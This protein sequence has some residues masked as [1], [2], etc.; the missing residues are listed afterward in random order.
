MINVNEINRKINAFK[1][2]IKKNICKISVVQNKGLVNIKK[3]LINNVY[4]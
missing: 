4:R 1:K 2:K 3:L